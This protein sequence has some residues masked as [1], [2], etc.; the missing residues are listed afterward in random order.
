MHDRFERRIEQK[1]RAMAEGCGKRKQDR[2]KVRL[3]L[4]KLQQNRSLVSGRHANI[5]CR[6]ELG[7]TFPERTFRHEK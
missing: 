4:Y 3:R 6:S 7:I 1:P 2:L 5:A